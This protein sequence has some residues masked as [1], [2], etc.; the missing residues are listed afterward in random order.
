MSFILVTLMQWTQIISYAIK[1][2]KGR[3]E[4]KKGER[5]GKNGNKE[6]KRK[7]RRQESTSNLNKA[8]EI[9]ARIENKTQEKI[10]LFFFF[11]CLFVFSFGHFYQ[12]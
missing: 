4:G 12:N 7:E 3:K 11:V 5:E 2:K 6:S 1:R 8:I 9:G 10:A